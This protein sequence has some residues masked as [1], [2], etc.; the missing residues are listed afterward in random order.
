MKIFPATPGLLLLTTLLGCDSP[1]N[2]SSAAQSAAESTPPV[3]VQVAEVTTAD[4]PVTVA[5]TGTLFG[6]EQTTISA[7]V[8]GKIAELFADVGDRVAP[9][10]PLA[11]LDP[12]DYQIELLQKELAVK[13]ALA[14]LGLQ[15]LPQQDFDVTR[16]ATVERARFQREN[17]K[18]RLERA[19]MLMQNVPPPISEQEFADIQT[20][21]EVAQRDF[22][23]AVLEAQAQIAMAR[24]RDAE[25][26][27]ARSRL[28]DTLIRAP[29][30]RTQTPG[31]Q[32]AVAGRLVS[33][34]EFVTVGANLFRLVA[35]R[36]IKFRGAMPERYT[37]TVAPGQRARLHV[38]GIGEVEGTVSRVNPA[39]DPASRTFEVEIVTPNSDGR[40]RPG[41]FARADVI[42]GEAR[43]VQL[44]PA[45]AVVSF[46]GV[47]RV[48]IVQDG[49]ARGVRISPRESVG[50]RVAI[51]E[52]LPPGAPIILRGDRGVAEGVPVEIQSEEPAKS[53]G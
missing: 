47:D 28:E 46:A 12:T 10:A 35:D 17:A 44:V 29:L 2:P 27:A 37:S 4:L 33:V 3:R 14:K 7:K 34:G 11:Q 48:F 20:Q 39:V 25:A 41:A 38:E 49:K 42:V 51:A 9:G 32:F 26:Q 43:D 45:A 19:A 16:I 40:L 22:D 52:R 21:Y 8:S 13:E 23:V 15:S 5:V 1:R 6:D 36:P 53:G 18:A 30:R 24:A 31:D 50:N